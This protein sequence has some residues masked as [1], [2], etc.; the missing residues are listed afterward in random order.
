MTGHKLGRK[1]RFAVQRAT[2]IFQ[3]IGWPAGRPRS[4][5]NRMT[6]CASVVVFTTAT[7]LSAFAHPH[8][9]INNKM[10][11]LFEAKEL[12]GIIFR[13][14]FD[15]SFSD[16]ILEDHKPNPDGSFSA[17][18]TGDI[19]VEAFDNLESYHYFLAFYLDDVLLPKISIER[20]TPSVAGGH[21]VYSF[22]VP[23]NLPAAKKQQTVRVTVYDDTYFVAFDPM[24]PGDAMVK[25]SQGLSVTLSV[26]QVKAKADWPGQYPPDQLVIR[27]KLTS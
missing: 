21:L 6:R 19:R 22:F 5:G 1:G 3:S 13:W 14:V 23:L 25:G 15:D 16:M 26:E 24:H 4:H 9:F 20:F 12:R 10:T 7:I 8:V 27:Y 2:A 17:R 11:V 18:T